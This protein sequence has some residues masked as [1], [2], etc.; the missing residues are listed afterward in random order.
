MQAD[1]LEAYFARVGHHGSREPVVETLAAL[2]LAHVG[3]IPFESLDPFLGRGVAID[4][5]ALVKK[6]VHGSRGGYCFEQNGLFLQVL[7]ALGFRATPL[8]ARVRWMA[9]DDAPP[10]PLS[11]MLL[12]VHLAEGD[13]FCDVG[14]GS[15]SPTAPLRFEPGLEQE[16]PHGRYRVV[17]KDGVY[18]VEARLPDRWALM[19]L[20]RVEPQS[21]RDYE[22]FNWFTATHPQSR[23][24]NNLVAARVVGASRLALLNREFT[25]HHADGRTERTAIETPE[26]LHHIL[27]RDFGIRIEE[28][29]IV[30]AWPRLPEPDRRTG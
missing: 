29:E 5:P 2:Q 17:G 7:T 13:V 21:P 6:L 25:I 18:G 14:F 9:P 15:Q 19:Y 26:A 11:H 10:S 28:A 3:T 22:V 16:T 24:V 20:F 1:E 8:A 30:R 23:F 27:S 4:P 12:F